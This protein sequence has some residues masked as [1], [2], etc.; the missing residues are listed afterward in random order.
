MTVAHT[1]DLTE[2]N[3][4][5]W[6]ELCGSALAQA[7]GITDR[8]ADSLVKFDDAYLAMY[9]Y[10]LR[11]VPVGRFAGLQVLEI[12]LGYGTLGQ[13][14]AQS[15]ASYTGL[16]LAVGPVEMMRHRLEARGIAGRVIQ[17]S[18][19]DAPFADGSF[20]RVVSIGCFHHTGDT[21]RCLD[22][23]WRVLR[24]GGTAHLMVYN[25]YGARQWA[26]RRGR[27]LA[28]WLAERRLGSG[29]APAA[30]GRCA[31]D[32][33]T[34]G[35]PAPETEFFSTRQLKRMLGRYRRVDLAKENIGAL[36]VRGRVL[37][38]RPVLL[39]TVGRIAGQ[40]I[41]IRAEK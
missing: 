18:M 4:R 2:A 7:L 14:I 28:E 12:G 5:F 9:P 15:C 21:Q 32:W 13:S 41:Y 34:A 33:N 11:H 40:D 10:L 37:I 27:L 20:D 24:P 30:R 35:M 3:R 25:R 6:D 38:P 31:L 17:G 29:A 23:T 19:L 22:E 16:D 36:R 26:E 8:S 1:R 39:R